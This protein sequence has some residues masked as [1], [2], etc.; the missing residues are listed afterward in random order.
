MERWH[1]HWVDPRYDEAV[2]AK[3]FKSLLPFPCLLFRWQKEHPQDVKTI[4]KIGSHRTG[5]LHCEGKCSSIDR[6]MRSVFV[7]SIA[8]ILLKR[9]EAIEQ[10]SLL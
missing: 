5:H 2:T 10:L 7:Q 6:W 8:I 1:K 4:A 9:A 3:S